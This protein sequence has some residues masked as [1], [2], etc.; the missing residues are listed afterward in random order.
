MVLQIMSKRWLQ[1]QMGEYL[2][3]INKKGSRETNGL[4]FTHGHMWQSPYKVIIKSNA[5]LFWSTERETPSFLL[6]IVPVDDRSCSCS[7]SCSCLDLCSCS[8]GS[9]FLLLLLLRESQQKVTP[10]LPRICGSKRFS[11]FVG[12]RGKGGV[13]N[14]ERGMMVEQRPILEAFFFYVSINFFHNSVR[15]LQSR[16]KN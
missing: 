13:M 1:M 4:C 8:C 11:G 3:L 16:T 6:T 14:R 15:F 10:S 7:C 12:R 2:L 9:L 5:C